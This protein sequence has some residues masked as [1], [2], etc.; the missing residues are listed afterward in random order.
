LELPGGSV[1]LYDGGGFSDNRSFDVGKQVVAPLLWRRKIATVDTLILSHPNADHLN[2]LIFVAG[3]FNV[4]ELWVNGDANTTQ[5]YKTLM[6][7]CREKKILVRRLD[8]DSLPVKMGGVSLTVLHPPADFIDAATA[9][10]QQDRNNGSLVVKV[11]FGKT[12]F[13]LTGDIMADAESTLLRRADGNLA[14]TVLFAPHHGSRS[15]STPGLIQAVRPKTVVISSGAG[16]RFGFPHLDVTDRYRAAGCRI[17]ITATHGAITMRSDG[18]GVQI[19]SIL[20]E[21]PILD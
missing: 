17:L 6:A 8:A 2:G 18:S 20:A 11:A 4:R 9:I 21:S 12:A 5:G 19:E 10:D 15:S 14:S 13:L 1:I 7:V 3:H 16:N